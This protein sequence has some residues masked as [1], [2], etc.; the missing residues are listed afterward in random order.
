MDLQDRLLSS[1]SRA[2]QIIG[3]QPSFADFAR[4]ALS[5]EL[6]EP[7]GG[8]RIVPFYPTIEAA[9]AG[10]RT[11]R[12]TSKWRD[13]GNDRTIGKPFERNR[14][15]IARVPLTSAF[16]LVLHATKGWRKVPV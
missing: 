3:G 11:N 5:R 8:E 1:V 14:R 16:D 15:H 2:A 4:E 12:R 9:H 6:R 13:R 7:E 10:L